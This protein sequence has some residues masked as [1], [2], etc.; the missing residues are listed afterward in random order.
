M[1]ARAAMAAAPAMQRKAV[2]LGVIAVRAAWSLARLRR[3]LL[4]LRLTAGDERRQAIDTGVV[5][6]RRRLL[7]ARLEMLRLGLRLLRLAGVERLRLARRERFPADVRL[8]VV[9][10]IERV[11]RKIAAHLALL[12]LVIGLGLS[13]LFLRG[14]DQAEIMLGMLVIVFGGDRVAGTLRV[15]RE[16]QV[17][18]GDVG[19]RSANFH[20]RSVRLVH[21]RQR[22]LVVTTFA[23]ATP[24]ALILTVSHGLLFCQPPSLPAVRMPAFLSEKSPLLRLPSDASA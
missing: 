2:R 19:R 22:I 16:L 18:L 13:E 15:A 14:R 5:G 4:V 23:V 20:V 8:V 1:V 24:H 3:L 9:S 12:L 11:V 21:A 17:L 6:R 10:I 7:R